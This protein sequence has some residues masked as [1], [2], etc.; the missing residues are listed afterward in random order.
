MTQLPI[1]RTRNT[2]APDAAR[3]SSISRLSPSLRASLGRGYA[4]AYMTARRPERAIETFISGPKY[5]AVITGMLDSV[6]AKKPGRVLKRLRP[7]LR[8]VFGAPEI[9]SWTRDRKMITAS[10]LTYADNAR[11]VD[12]ENG[13]TLFKERALFLHD[14]VITG[15]RHG[16]VNSNVISHTSLNHHALRRIIERGGADPETLSESV[17]SALV[18]ARHIA[19]HIP[20]TRIDGQQTMAYL[21]PFAGGALCCVELHALPDADFPDAKRRIL[22]VRTFLRED[23]LGVDQHDRMCGY[24]RIFCADTFDRDAACAWVARNTVRWRRTTVDRKAGAYSAGDTDSDRADHRE[25]A[26]ALA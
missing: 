15:D 1:E 18:R 25:P 12:P 21:V 20:K 5:D 11:I 26:A 7:H 22:S 10:S 17:W 14:L 19:L 3:I 23:M 8:G 6:H 13:A 16:A 4:T 24:E 2:Q 9:V